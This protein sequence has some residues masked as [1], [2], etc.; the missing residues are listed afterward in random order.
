MKFVLD[1]NAAKAKS[2]IHN[3]ITSPLQNNQTNIKNDLY[4]CALYFVW[5]RIEVG[6]EKLAHKPAK[7]ILQSRN[8]TNRQ[9][10]TGMLS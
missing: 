8:K 9:L 3:T 5:K 6:I 2:T 1:Y 7:S 4:C 10:V